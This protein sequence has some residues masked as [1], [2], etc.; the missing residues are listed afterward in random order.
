MSI[1]VS[2]RDKFSLFTLMDWYLRYAVAFTVCRR[3]GHFPVPL[4]FDG[5]S[6]CLRCTNDLPNTLENP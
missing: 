5:S 1:K 6:W 2:E 3:Y 4:Q